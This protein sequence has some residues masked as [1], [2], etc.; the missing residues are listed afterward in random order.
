MKLDSAIFYTNNLSKAID[1]YS[2][3]L[4]FKVDY[5]Q[6]NRFASFIFNNDAKLGIKQVRED[7]EIPGSQAVFIECENIQEVFDDLKSQGVNILKQLT[8]EDWATNFSILDPDKNK[9]Q[10]VKYN[11]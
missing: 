9:I 2:Q 5:I 4:K 1:F 10:F 8:N 3:I 7:R 6:D 11:I